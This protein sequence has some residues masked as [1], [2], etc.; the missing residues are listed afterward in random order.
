MKETVSKISKR[1]K[2]TNATL[3]LA[4]AGGLTSA[5]INRAESSP[6]DQ[7]GRCE[8][9]SIAFKYFDRYPFDGVGSNKPDPDDFALETANFSS[10]RVEAADGSSTR[11]FNMQEHPAGFSYGIYP[12]G[13]FCNK[14]IYLSYPIDDQNPNRGRLAWTVVPGNPNIIVGGRGA[15][16]ENILEFRKSQ[17]ALAQNNPTPRLGNA[18]YEALIRLR[19]E[20]ANQPSYLNW[21]KPN[22]NPAE[23]SKKIV[24]LLTQEISKLEKVPTPPSSNETSKS[25]ELQLQKKVIEAEARLNQLQTEHAL[26]KEAKA[27]AD[28]KLGEA[29]TKLEQTNKRVTALEQSIESAKQQA[30]QIEANKGYIRK[31]M[32]WLSSFAS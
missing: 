4:L 28:Q 7:S 2:I 10:F 6:T 9:G 31:I 16:S 12:A 20:L 5:S 24:G 15:R 30:A 1:S 14:S 18:A 21:T 29:N 26:L 19:P 32:D 17:L 23:N 3:S 11:I 8:I 27:E 25:S 22:D 13:E